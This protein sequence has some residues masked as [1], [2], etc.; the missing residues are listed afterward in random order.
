MQALDNVGAGL[1]FVR[2]DKVLDDTVVEN[3]YSEIGATSGGKEL[4]DSLVDGE[5]GS[6][7]MVPASLVA[8]PGAERC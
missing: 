4:E 2:L 7:A 1:L 3:F 6:L 5:E 8:W